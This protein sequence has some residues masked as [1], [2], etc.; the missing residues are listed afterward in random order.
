MIGKGEM[1]IKETERLFINKLVVFIYFIFKNS[2]WNILGDGICI[3][4]VCI[5]LR[6]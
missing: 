4:L 2:T 1:K 3:F 6:H 5:Y